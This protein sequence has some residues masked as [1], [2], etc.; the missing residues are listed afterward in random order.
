MNKQTYFLISFYL[1]LIAGSSTEAQQWSPEHVYYGRGGILTYTP[2]EQGNIIPDFSHVGYRFGDEEIPYIETAV[3]VSPV[4]GDDGTTIQAAIES[5]Y[6]VVPDENGFRGTVLLKAGNYEVSGQIRIAESGIVLRGEGDTDEGTVITATGTDRRSLIRV[7]NGSSRSVETASKVDIV[8]EYVPLGRT[9]VV[10]NSASGFSEG[11]DIVLY[12][13]GTNKWISDIRMDQ[14]TA[15]AGVNQWSASSYSFYFERKITRINGD[16]LFFRNPVVMAMESQY[17]GGSVYKY[18]FNRL[19]NIGIEN[20]CLKSTYT[21]EDDEEHSWN[22]ILIESAEHSWV[23]KVSSWYF[24]YANTYLERESRHITVIDCHSHE[25][26]SIITGSRRYSFPV[27][28]SLCLVRDCSA[29]EGRHDYATHSRVTGPNVFCN[30]TAEKTY[31]DIGPHH[32]WAMGTLYDVITSDGEINVQDR[33][34]MGSGHGWAGANQVF[35]NCRGK[36]SI[37]ESPWASA[38]NYNFGFI[39]E[40]EA[41]FRPGRPNG[42]WIGH[43]VPGIFP[44]SLYDAQLDERLNDKRLFCAISALEQ[45]NDSTF[46][47]SFTMPVNPSGILPENFDIGG[48]AGVGNKTYS[49]EQ[50]DDWSVKFTF[51]DIG[52]L[53][54]FSTI[55]I[56]AKNIVSAEGKDMEGL[57]NAV[58]TE[59]D[60]RPLVSGVEVTVNNEDGF[61]VASSS[62]PGKIYLVKY[63]SDPATIEK[64]DSLV[65][66]NLGRSAEAPTPGVSVPIYTKG[67]PGGFYN[68][69]AVDEDFRVSA[70][71]SEWV[72]IEETGAVSNSAAKIDPELFRIYSTGEMIR[73]EP[74]NSEPYTIE[75]FTVTGRLLYRTGKLKGG[76]SLDVQPGGKIYIVRK[77]SAGGVSVK[78][79]FMQ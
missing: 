34:D 24:A 7:H 69:Y 28:G 52:I 10:V 50:V 9:F 23:R 21:S 60:K 45:S 30:S 16:S 67:L 46:I 4:D 44:S 25:P 68:Y 33:D 3:E 51:T 71:A 8:E 65:T 29:S 38:K 22:G 18:T 54:A 36:S 64:L 78:K 56:T 63:G 17:G 73:V 14:I 70:P 5:L 74:G 53:Q 27:A 39:G 15:S 77:R 20:L 75:I 37:C 61:G 26:K 1:L 41:G 55:S 59:P 32:R 48:T 6:S 58:F 31:A 76:Q 42:E 19:Q 2:D 11:E 40:Q 47:M 12:R 72:V 66:Q 13:P 35:W 43:N 62:R 57:F 79:I 49:L